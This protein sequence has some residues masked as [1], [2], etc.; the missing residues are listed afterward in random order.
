[1]QRSSVRTAAAI[2]LRTAFLAPA[3]RTSPD[4]GLPPVITNFCMDRCSLV[5]GSHPRRAHAGRDPA[6]LRQVPR[7]RAL[8]DELHGRGPFP[9]SGGVVRGPF[10]RLAPVWRAFVTTRV[11]ASFA[12]GPHYPG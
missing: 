7:I 9:R 6:P 8:A 4:S 11:A 2:I 12:V 10:S 1:M 5:A 3:M